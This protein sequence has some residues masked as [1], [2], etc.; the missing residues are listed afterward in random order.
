MNEKEAE[1]TL[2]VAAAK[3][4]EET[5]KAKFE[6][7]D[8]RTQASPDENKMDRELRARDYTKRG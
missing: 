1:K 4:A 2:E 3:E 7:W 5:L 8:K 6:A